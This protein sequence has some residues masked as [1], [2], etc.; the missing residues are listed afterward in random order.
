MINSIIN[1]QLSYNYLYLNNQYK[2]YRL[3]YN[4]IF[5]IKFMPLESK[6][7]DFKGILTIYYKIRLIISMF[8]SIL[9]IF[10]HIKINIFNNIIKY[11]EKTNDIFKY[12]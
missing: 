12:F 5:K 9:L 10:T 2:N 7:I 8:K 11:I 1:L 4:Y 6:K 3:E